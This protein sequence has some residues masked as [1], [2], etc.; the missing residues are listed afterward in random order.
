MVAPIFGAHCGAATL[1]ISDHW[2]RMRHWGIF[3][4]VISVI[5]VIIHFAGLPL[6]TD[7]YSFS[8]LLLSTGVCMIILCV[9]YFVVDY[10]PSR[11]EGQSA[12]RH[13]HPILRPF[14]WYNVDTLIHFIEN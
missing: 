13:V 14:H 7:L 10:L 2:E 6:N 9:S 4:F 11:Y 5:G 8:Y 3:G 12:A 1:V